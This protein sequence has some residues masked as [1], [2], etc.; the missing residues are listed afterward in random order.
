MPI[1]FEELIVTKEKIVSFLLQEYCLDIGRVTDYERV[2][3]EYFGK[4]KV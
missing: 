2:N 4:F 1:L 3:I